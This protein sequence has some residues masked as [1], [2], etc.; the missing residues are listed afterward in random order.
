MC[1]E[2]S[3]V[4]HDFSVKRCEKIAYVSL[5]TTQ[6]IFNSIHMYSRITSGRVLDG[7][8]L[9]IEISRIFVDIFNSCKLPCVENLVMLSNSN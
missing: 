8:L 9:W 4:S 5:Q 7:E 6:D 2:M 3:T 1:F